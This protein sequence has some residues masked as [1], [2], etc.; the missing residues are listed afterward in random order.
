VDAA[1]GPVARALRALE[2]VQSH[3]GITAVELGERLGV[4]DRAARRYVATLREAGIPVEA[5]RGRHGGYRLGRGVRLPPLTFTSEEV[6]GLVMAVLE[7]P[8]APGPDDPLGTALGKI[9]RALPEAVARDAAAVRSRVAASPARTESRP[10]PATASTLAAAAAERRRVRITYRSASGRDWDTEVDPWAVV[11]RWGYWYLLCRAHHADAVRTLRIDRVRRVVEV[12]GSFEPPPDLDPTALLEE[13]LGQGWEHETRV[14]VDAPVDR[15][16]PWVTPPMGRV[17]ALGG[18]ERTLLVG[19]TSNP[20]MYAGEWLSRMPFAFRVEGG[21]ELR[22]AVAEV[23]A[24]MTAAVADD[25]TT[26][27]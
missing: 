27:G 15:V 12:P 11:V 14:V 23:A 21:P 1:A 13:H 3:P 25:A 20:Q 24:R 9:L 2:I 4:S 16:R 6:L 7:G 26:P 8:S 5:V 18:G 22:A 17:E 19:S 10:R